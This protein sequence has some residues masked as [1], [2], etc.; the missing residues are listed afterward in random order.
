MTTQLFK[1]TIGTSV[2]MERTSMVVER[3]KLTKLCPIAIAQ[4]VTEIL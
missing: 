3:P 4:H 2:V 1:N